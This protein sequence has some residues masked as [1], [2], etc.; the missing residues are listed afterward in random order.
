[1]YSNMSK[2]ILFWIDVGLEHFGIAKYINELTDYELNVIFDVNDKLKDSLE[3][4]KIVNFKNNE[5]FARR[6]SPPK[7]IIEPILPKFT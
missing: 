6:L 2:R 3:N 5:K 4:Q 7:S 1:M